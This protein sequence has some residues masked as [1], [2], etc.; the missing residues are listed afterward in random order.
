MKKTLL[1]IVKDILSDLDSEDVN[2]ISDSVEA[3][4]VAKIVEQTF[5]DLIATRKIPE[6]E[7]L[8]KLTSLSDSNFPTHFVLQDNQAKLKALWY[9]V[10]DTGVY[11]YK[12]IRYLEPTEFLK[13]VDARRGED[14]TLINDKVA[15]TKLRITNNLQPTYYTSFDDEHIVLDSW[16]SSVEATLQSNKTRALGTTYP[17]FSVSDSYEPDLDAVMFPYLVNESKSRAFSVL[18]GAIDQKVEQSARRQKVHVQN[19]KYRTQAPSKK[20]N[21]GRR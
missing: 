5:Y 19:D 16:D 11:E 13:L 2:S 18:K 9:D 17:T 6:H 7:S 1:E 15:G 3:L 8:I 14:Y 20:R 12:E 21:Y 10:S 4:Q